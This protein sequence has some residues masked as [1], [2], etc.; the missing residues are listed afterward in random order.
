MGLIPTEGVAPLGPTFDTLG[1]ITRTVS[2]A[3]LLTEAMAGISLSHPPVSIAGLR[4]AVA[5]DAEL[6]PMSGTVAGAYAVA[7]SS[8]RA[9]GAR[10]EEIELPLSF[11]EFQKLNGDIVAFEAYRHLAHLVDDPATPLDPYVRTRVLVGKRISPTQYEDR[12]NRLAEVRS[13]FDEV[14]TCHDALVLPGTPTCALP[15]SDVDESSIPMSRYTR[16][17][18]CLDLCAISLPV[19]RDAGEL[20]V[21]LQICGPAHSDARLLAIASEAIGV[22]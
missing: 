22:I 13:R 6:A 2:E 3:R 16:V 5:S 20:P 8:L 21:G 12:L 9:Q 4:I 19:T 18:N 1:P 15:L 17:A 14:W 7:L 10:I 11:V